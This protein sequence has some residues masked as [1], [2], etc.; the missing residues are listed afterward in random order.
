MLHILSQG[1]WRGMPGM[2]DGR[3][4][5]MGLKGTVL[6]II[7]ELGERGAVCLTGLGEMGTGENSKYL[8]DCG[9]AGILSL[10]SLA[11]LVLSCPVL[12]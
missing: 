3:R 2:A 6:G 4:G 9:D 11:C 7:E 12:K 8:T 5:K 1:V 10:L